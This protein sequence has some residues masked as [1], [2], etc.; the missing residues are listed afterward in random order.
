MMFCKALHVSDGNTDSVI[1]AVSSGCGMSV[2]D[3]ETIDGSIVELWNTRDHAPAAPVPASD[4]FVEKLLAKWE[5]NPDNMVFGTAKTLRVIT[6][7][8]RAELE[9]PRLT[10]Q[11][12]R[13]IVASRIVAFEDQG[14]DA[15]KE[16]DEA[17]EAFAD[18]VEW[19]DEPAA[20]SVRSAA[21]SATPASYLRDIPQRDGLFVTI[22]ADKSDPG[23]Y[24]VYAAPTTSP[25]PDAV[26][27]LIAYATTEAEDASKRQAEAYA[28]KTPRGDIEGERWNARQLAFLD[29]RRQ[30]K[31]ALSRP[32]HG[33]WYAD[34]PTEAQINAAAEVMWTDRD[35]SRGGPWSSRGRDEIVVIQ[36]KATAKA[37]LQAAAL[38]R[39]DRGSQTHG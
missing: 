38:A 8:I 10:K 1:H 34:D 28:K 5:A 25:E 27:D 15:I 3:N 33:G 32:A 18:Q 13:L 31:F 30:M 12:R 11:M 17:S 9:R 24:P 20:P 36:T 39:N 6:K 26:R 22:I 7:A 37:A 35:A 14:P 19:D 4:A 2:F 16:L 29:M 21:T 23:A